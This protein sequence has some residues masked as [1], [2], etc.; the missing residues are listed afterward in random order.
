[1]S[2]CLVTQGKTSA[3]YSAES[4]WNTAYWEKRESLGILPIG[5]SGYRKSWFLLQMQWGCFRRASLLFQR[6]QLGTQSWAWMIKK[7]QKGKSF[8]SP[9]KSLASFGEQWREWLL[10]HLLLNLPGTWCRITCLSFPSLVLSPHVIDTTDL[11][12]CLYSH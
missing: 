3:L 7:K 10:H 6:D 5:D 9:F 8:N 2:E 4:S 1:M 11:M 12:Q